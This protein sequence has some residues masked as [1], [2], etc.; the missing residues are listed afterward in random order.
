MN[1]TRQNPRV[2]QNSI[3]S[4]CVPSGMY[5]NSEWKF[6]PQPTLH[7]QKEIKVLSAGGWQEYQG[8]FGALLDMYM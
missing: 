5:S 2:H 3:D 4:V 1:K 6:S 8:G 7:V